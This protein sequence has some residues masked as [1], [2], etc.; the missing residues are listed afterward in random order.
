MRLARVGGAW[1][2]LA[3]VCVTLLAS[4]TSPTAAPPTHS[5]PDRLSDAE[6]WRIVTDFSEGDGYFQS[7]NL[8]SNELTFQWVIPRLK[9]LW[10]PGRVYLGVGPDQ[11]F[12]YLASLKPSIAFIVDIRRDNLRLQLLYKALI[13]MSPTRATF[14]SRLLSRDVPVALTSGAGV[15]A[16]VGEMFQAFASV[17]PSEALFGETLKA[18]RERLSVQHGFVLSAADLS[19]LEYV[20]TAFFYNGPSL[21]YANTLRMGRYPSYQDLMVATD[22]AGVARGYLANEPS[23][24]VLR[25]MQLRNLVVPVVG[26]FTGDKALQSVAR[27][28]KS[29]NAVV[30]AIYT[31]NVEQYLFQYGTWPSYYANVQAL[32]IDDASQ[33]IRSCFNTCASVPWSRSAQLL[34][35]VSAL[36]K[37]VSAGRVFS[38]YD[39]LAR[40]R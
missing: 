12:T 20:L 10:T 30:G 40:S 14:L 21:A 13:E 28:L 17:K 1:R 36:L 19:H 29:R 31:S 5:L 26:D 24:A 16:P 23:Y 25:E 3:A 37:D 4:V 6:F 35:P 7:D 32:P 9:A 22:E 15:E 27:Y 39:L 34:D 8:V 33:F 38:Y 18:V 2:L 11:N